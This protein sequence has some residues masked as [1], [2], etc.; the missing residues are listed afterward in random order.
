MY[1]VGDHHE[2]PASTPIDLDRSHEHRRT[3]AGTSK[4]NIDTSAKP[5]NRMTSPNDEARE[6]RDARKNKMR[7][8]RE[9]PEGVCYGFRGFGN[10]M[11][12]IRK[13]EQNSLRFR[14]R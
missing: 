7:E 5:D 10:G 1:A 14:N 11:D 3:R 12:A 4:G 8:K 9:C 2:F 6:D 13:Q